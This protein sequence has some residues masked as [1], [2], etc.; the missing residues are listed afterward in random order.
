MKTR[1]LLALTLACI[2]A[3]SAQAQVKIISA[4][5]GLP[6]PGRTVDVRK[7]V[8]AKVDAGAYSFRVHVASFGIDPN[9]GRPNYLVVEYIGP[10]GNKLT[11]RKEDGGVFNF[12][13]AG[14]TY[15][16][17]AQVARGTPL[18]FQNGYGRAIYVYE[19]DRWASWQWKAQLDPGSTYTANGEIG[20]RW[21]VTDR[22]GRVLREVKVSRD[23]AP[24]YLR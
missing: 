4:H 13:V 15:N 14:R 22:N 7:L 24:V 2:A 5:Y 1:L 20:D 3:T 21:I 9:P 10:N 6:K 11:G 16:P 8:Q 23:M 12:L 19:L 17:P 18:R